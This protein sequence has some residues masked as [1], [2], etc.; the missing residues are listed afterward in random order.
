[1]NKYISGENVSAHYLISDRVDSR[2]R[3][4]FVY[5]L[6]KEQRLAWLAGMSN[7]NG[8]ANL[9]DSLIGVEIVNPGL[10]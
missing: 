5:R 6:I 9:N 1:M 4:Q 8:L 10:T 2:M 3:K 7:L